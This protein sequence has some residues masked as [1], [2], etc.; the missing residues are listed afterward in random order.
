MNKEFK[1][2]LVFWFSQSL[3]QMGSS[4]T[5]FALI[6]WAYSQ[7]GTAMT[8]SLMSFFNY[9]PYIIVSAFAGTFVD[10][11][12]KKTIMLVTDSIAALCSVIILILSVSNRLYIWHIYAVNFMIGFMNAFQS[13]ASAVAIGKIVPKEKLEQISG[14]NSFSSNLVAVLSPIISASLF[15]FL[16][17]H[18]IIAIDLCTFAFAFFV[19]LLVLRIPED[20]KNVRKEISIMRGTVQGVKFLMKHKPVFMTVITLAILNFFSRLT[21]ENILSPMIL[22]RSGDNNIA[23]GI[24]NAIMGI[25]GIIG[26][27]LV[28]S[29]R[30]KANNAK[31]IYLSAFVSFLLGDIMMAIGKGTLLWAFAGLAASLPIPFIT[32]GSNMILYE[33]VPTEMQGRVFA[34]RNSIQYSTIPIGILL[35]GFFADYV[36]EPLMTKNNTVTSILRCIVG[37]GDGSGMAVMFLCT[38]ILGSMFSLIMYSQKDIRKL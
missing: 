20:R 29:G 30:I 19:L 2:Y 21:Y 8:I 18:V 5:S 33:Y 27:V 7:K 15:G 17:L 6:L 13:P 23:L 1:R 34:V 10:R 14:M 25:G 4:M 9:L 24:V 28:A 31:M 16:G 36:F 37:G 3:S 35:G 12:R 38:G 22:A 11:H 32:A 26:G